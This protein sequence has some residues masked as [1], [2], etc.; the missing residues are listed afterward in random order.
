[1]QIR[2]SDYPVNLPFF[3]LCLTNAVQIESNRPEWWDK[4][5]SGG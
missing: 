3:S 1:M 2:G 4:A 5:I